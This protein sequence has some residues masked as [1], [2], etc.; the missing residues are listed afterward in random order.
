MLHFGERHF[1][2]DHGGFL[3]ADRVGNA[4]AVDGFIVFEVDGG[5]FGSLGGRECKV[6]TH[7]Q[8]GFLV[9]VEGFLVSGAGLGIEDPGGAVIEGS[10]ALDRE[11][12]EGLLEGE[13]LVEECI[14]QG[15]FEFLAGFGGGGG[16]GGG[17]PGGLAIAD[18]EGFAEAGE[19]E[20]NEAFVWGFAEVE[21]IGI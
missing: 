16:S 21:E 19:I 4:Y 6:F 2:G 18:F 7:E 15:T 5:V 12:W 17:G 8:A 20:F 14:A 3:Q 10:G 1:E 9:E 11:G 13:F